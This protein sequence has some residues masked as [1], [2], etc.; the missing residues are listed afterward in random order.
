MMDAWER[1]GAV[2]SI[3][4]W[5]YGVPLGRRLGWWKSGRKQRRASAV[6]VGGTNDVEG[7][8]GKERKE[9]R[10]AWATVNSVERRGRR[11]AHSGWRRGEERHSGK[12]TEWR[13]P[14]QQ[15]GKGEPHRMSDQR[16]NEGRGSGREGRMTRQGTRL[17][18]EERKRPTSE[19]ARCRID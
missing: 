4:C 1:Y 16:I 3:K 11:C 10:R 7:E 6:D 5:M 2:F 18:A 15:T 12:A 17:R 19:E 14:R 8:E 13:L 9:D